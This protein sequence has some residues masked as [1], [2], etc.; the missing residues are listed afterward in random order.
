MC[1]QSE[2]KEAW[3]LTDTSWNQK[4]ELS[5]CRTG[6]AKSL[7]QILLLLVQGFS[8]EELL[9]ASELCMCQSLANT[10]QL[11][12]YEISKKMSIWLI[13]HG[14]WCEYI[15]H[16]LK[17]IINPK[18]LF[19]LYP[20]NCKNTSSILSIWAIQKDLEWKRNVPLRFSSSCVTWRAMSKLI[21]SFSRLGTSTFCALQACN[22]CLWFLVYPG[23]KLI[24]G[25]WR[26]EDLLSQWC[27]WRTC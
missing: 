5:T 7:H 16:P 19:Y 1:C 23:W 15:G 11:C 20:E 18:V 4:P 2:H 9:H 8:L 3:P 14:I 26:V 25:H 10:A 27:W 24:P 6:D 17:S 22:L 21:S 12:S 13:M